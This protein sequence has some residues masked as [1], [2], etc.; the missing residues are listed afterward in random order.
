MCQVNKRVSHRTS[1]VQGSLARSVHICNSV[2]CMH[3]PRLFADVSKM[4]VHFN[5]GI[6][7]TQSSI[8][9]MV[10]H[11][12]RCFSSASVRSLSNTLHHIQNC[13]HNIICALYTSTKWQWIST[14]V[15]PYTW[16][17]KITLCTLTRTM[18]PLGLPSLDCIHE[19]MRP[20]WTQGLLAIIQQRILSSSLRTTNIKFK[21]YR[22]AILPVVL[23][24]QE[25]RVWSFSLTENIGWGCLK[26]Q[27]AKEES[28][29][30]TEQGNRGVNQ[31]D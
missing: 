17:N 30:K 10:G 2:G 26:K 25:I 28:W 5:K 21:I 4:S 13:G 7:M 8:V 15:R 24:G 29:A 23:H 22:T 16:R 1:I 31:L 27:G 6:C 9:V 18:F 19:E 11:P 20:D 14:A 12:S 3:Y